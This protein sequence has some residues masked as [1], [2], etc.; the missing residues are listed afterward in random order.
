M[1]PQQ[2]S[3]PVSYNS[4]PGRGKSILTTILLVILLIGA[5]AF[6]A[7]AF[8]GMQDYKTKSDQKSAV[9]V[10]AAKKDQASELQAQFNEQSKSPNKTYVG[11]PTYGTVSF[12]YPKTWSG[13]VDTTSTTEPINAYFHPDV[14]PG[15]Q[16]KSTY[17]LRM[18]LLSTDYAQVLQQFSYQ[19]TSGTVK[20]VAFTPAKLVGVAN[21]QPGTMLSGQ[22]N[23][24][25]RT[26]TGKLL[27]IKVRDKTLLIS[28]QSNEFLTDYDSIVLPSLSFVP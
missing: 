17:S 5:V 6:G 9:A 13:Y 27:V 7:W 14:V 19:I 1:N 25:D 20:A 4:G 16:S 26:Q 12:S 3:S 23:S 22:I 10:T 11:S 21:V 18:E 15:L 2:A 24:Q 28:T 8:M